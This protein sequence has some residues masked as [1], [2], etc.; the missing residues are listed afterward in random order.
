MTSLDPRVSDN[1]VGSRNHRS[2]PQRANASGDG[3]YQQVLRRSGQCPDLF[4]S[5]G[6]EGR[7]SAF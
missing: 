4:E 5:N 3:S 7:S 6:P 2:R 1:G